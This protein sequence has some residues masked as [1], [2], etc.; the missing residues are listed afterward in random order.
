M[1]FAILI[2]LLAFAISQRIGLGARELVRLPLPDAL[3][4]LFSQF[5]GSGRFVW[6]A[7]YALLAASIVAV[8]RRYEGQAR[9]ADPGRRCGAAGGRC[10]ADAARRARGQLQVR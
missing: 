5:R 2:L 7:V 1:L 3:L 8:V 10:V 9:C 6:V 4:H